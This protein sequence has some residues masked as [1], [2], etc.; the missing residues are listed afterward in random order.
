MR[1]KL[2][3]GQIILNLS[4]ILVCLTYILP[5]LMLISISLSDEAT[6]REFGYTV[7]PKNISFDA[8]KLIFKNP[9]RIWMHI[10]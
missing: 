10:K 7:F 1:K 4:F 5:F 6:I 3:L 9:T 2:S 8:Y